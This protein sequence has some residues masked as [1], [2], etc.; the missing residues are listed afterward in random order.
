LSTSKAQLSL[1]SAA[2]SSNSLSSSVILDLISSFPSSNQT[3][4]VAPEAC[5]SCWCISHVRTLATVYISHSRQLGVFHYDAVKS[6]NF[7]MNFT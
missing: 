5:Y 4:Q 7:Q 6:P 3:M 1:K 2:L